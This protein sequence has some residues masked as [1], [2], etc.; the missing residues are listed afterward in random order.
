MTLLY[1]DDSIYSY[2][3]LLYLDNWHKSLIYMIKSLY[4]IYK[5]S[6]STYSNIN[7]Y[8]T[9]AFH[10]LFKLNVFSFI[11]VKDMNTKK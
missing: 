5:S 10:N 7:L 1:L 2:I 4:L 8:A 9:P 11:P 6:Y 3:I